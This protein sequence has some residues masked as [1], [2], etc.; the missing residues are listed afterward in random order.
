MDEQW[1][2][3]AAQLGVWFAGSLGP[4]GSVYNVGEQVEIHGPIVP[5]ILERAHRIVLD[6]AETLRFTIADGPGPTGDP[7]ASDGPF[8]VRRDAQVPVRRLDFSADANP[9]EAAEAWLR[10][11]MD[12]AFDLVQGPLYAPALLTVGP[13]SHILY[14]RYHHVVMDAWSSALI[15]RRTAQVYS[16]MVTDQP[17]HGTPFPPFRTLLEREG[18]YRGSEEQETDRRYWLKRLRNAPA[19]VSLSDRPYSRP[20]EILRQ[21]TTLD[22]HLADT[23]RSAAAQ[24]GV[25]W[26]VLAVVATAAY[27]GA[28][29]GESTVSVGLPVSGRLDED[30]RN[31]PGMAVNV[32]PLHIAV[33]PELPLSKVAKQVWAQTTRAA[34]HSRYRMEDLR[35][36]LAWTTGA[37]LPYGPV[38]NVMAFDYDIDFG[39]HRARASSISRRYT[40]D[41]SIAFHEGER[42][43]SIEA[44]FDANNQMYSQE[45]LDAHVERFLLFLGRMANAGPDQRVGSL[46]LL[47]AAERA[48]VLGAW[49]GSAEAEAG[50]GA[51]AGAPVGTV[52]ALF[53]ERV[54][55]APDAAAVLSAGDEVAFTYVELNARANRLARL[56]VERGVGPEQVVALALPRSPELVVAVLAVLKA[57]AAYLPID[58]AY[59]VE[60]IG[61]MLRDAGPSVVLADSASVGLLPQEGV[62]ALVLNG[63]GVEER[64]AGLSAA[65]LSDADRVA[66]LVP[67]HPAYVIY[68]SGST[69]VPKGVV[70]HHAGLVNLA[71]AQ[72]EQWQ[73]DTHSR[74]LQF[75]S[76]SF[77]A[78]AS[79]IFTALLSGGA[80]VTADAEQLAPGAALA[81]VLRDASVSHCTLPPSALPLLEVADVPQSMTLVVAGE[82][83]GPDAVERWSA[84]RQMINAY[85]P[86][87]TTVC[88]TMSEPLSG[89]VVPPIGHPI[90][91]V[92]VYVLNAGLAPVPPG[93]PG[94]LYVAGAGVARGYLGRPGL[95]GQRFVADPYG[96]PGTRMYR[97]GDLARWNP[98]GTLQF[99]GRADDQVKLRG[100][101]IELGEIEAALTAA[102]GVVGAVAVI[103]EDRPGDHRLVGY[104]VPE[105]NSH[106]VDT[107][108]IRT[109][110][111]DRLPD[112]MVPAAVVT[113]TELPLTPNGKLD[114]KALPAPDYSSGN[115]P[116]R[117]PRDAR[118][119]ILAGL[120]AEVLGLESSQVSVEDD[121]FTLGGHSLLAMRLIGR[122][123]AVL[124]TD[125]AIRDLFT[126]PTIA[127][128][129]RTLDTGTDATSRPALLP[130]TTRPQPIPLSFAQRRLWF[131][132]RLEGPSP[133]YNVP[134]VLRLTGPL[135]ADALQAALG[136]VVERHEALRT[137]FPDVD[138]QPHQHICPAAEARPDLTVETIDEADLT[139]AIDQAVRHSFDLATELPLR[140]RLF[141][142]GED[143]HVLVLTIHH[144]AGDGW[145]MGP[146]ARDLST[147]YAARR[148]GHT[149]AWTPLPVQYADY[150]LWQRELLGDEGDPDSLLASQA[151]YWREALA[152]LPERLELPTDHPYPEQ[153][154][155]EGASL[156][157]H[158][159]A[160]LHQAL[161][162]LARSTQT[163]VFMVLQAAI[164]VLLHRLG[165]GTD[166]PIG[167]PVAGR[168]E[169]ELDDLVGF[170]VNTLVLRTD[171]TGDPTFTELLDRV[172]ERNLN[173]YAHQD[174][175]FESLVEA[176]NPTRSLAHHPLFQVTL[177]FNNTPPTSVNFPAVEAVREFADVQAARMDLTVNL[178]ERHGDD[179]APDGIAGVLTYRTDLFEPGTATALVE[180]LLRVLRAVADNPGG[181]VAAVG[182]LSDGERHQLI[183]RWNDTAAPVPSG[184]VTEL[185]Q[186]QAHATPDATALITDGAAHT[187]YAELNT[188][189]NQLARILI[190][191]DVGPEHVVAL[192][193]PRSPRLI[194]AVLAVLK[195]GAAYLP[196]DT[197]YPVDRIRFMVRD[198]RPTLVLTDTDTDTDTDTTTDGLWA[199]GTPV[200]RLDDPAVQAQLA[201]LDASDA[202]DPA[203]A[204]HPES[205]AYVIYTSGSTGV[206]KG[207]V[208]HHAGL[209]NLA[210]A[211]S[212]QWQIG[213]RSRVLQ[214]A[215]PS[216]DAAASE[217]FTALLSGGALVLAG[218]ERLMPG[219][220]LGRVARDAG[221]THCTLPPSALNVLDVADVPQSMTLVVAGE[222]CG[223]DAVERWSAGRQMI[224]AYGP[225]ETTVCATMSEPL[226][227]AVVPPIGRPIANVRTYVL[228]AG[229][230]PVPPGVPG[231]LYVAGAGVA[232]GYLGRPGLTGQRFVA[233]PYGPPGTRMY[234][235]GDL[236][237]WNPDGTLQFLGRADDQV[238]LRGF[239]IELGEIEAALKG[240]PGVAGAAAVIREDRPGDRRLVGYVVPENNSHGVDTVAI[241]NLL[242]DRLPDYMVPAAVVPLPQLPLT[243]NGKLDRKALPAPDYTLGATSTT[244]AP[245]TPEEKALTALYAEVLG[246]DPARIGLDDSFFALGGDSISSIVLVSRAR[247]HG[248]D[249]SPRDIFKDQTPKQL[250]RTARPLDVGRAQPVAD[251]GVGRV[252]LTPIMRWLIEPGHSFDTF[253][254][255]RLVQVPAGIGR[256]PLLEV[257]QA[258]LDRHD[259]LRAR[260]T[261]AGDEGEAALEVPRAG[262]KQ[263]DEVLT[264]VDCAGVSAA[265]RE[266]LMA[267]HARQAQDRL[268][269]YDGVM[270]QAVWFDNGPQESGRLLLT[271]HHLVVD[272]VSWRILLPDLA[273]AGAAVLAGR[274]PE[275]APVPTSFK[276][277][278]ERLGA[279]AIDPDREA[280]LTHWT[281]TL[282]GVEPALGERELSSSVDTA[283]QLLSLR[284]T[285]PVELSEALVGRVPAALHAGVD[286]VLLTAFVLAIA[287]WRNARGG[288][289]SSGG[290]AGNSLL[291][292]VEGHGR[293]DGLFDGVD[294]SRT[295][296]WFTAVTP[297]RLDPGRVSW[298]ELRRGGPAAGRALQRV[299]EQL[300]AASELRIDHGLLRHL[301][302][303][304]A[305]VLAALPEPQVAFNYFGRLPAGGARGAGDWQQVD[306][307]PATGG[308]DRRMRL[309]H[310]L[311]V[312]AVTAEGPS[313][314]QLTATWSWPRDVLAREDV[315]RLGAGWVAQLKALAAHA[316][317][318]DTA[319][320]TPSDLS[321]VS[322]SQNQISRLEKKWRAKR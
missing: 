259:M 221:V 37:G 102:P 11:D 100:F 78:A 133:T 316:D 79:E 232:R 220:A 303:R 298:G 321:L 84:G 35:R 189:A 34:R 141:S 205:P 284:V 77:D 307:V 158:V 172:R 61:F 194:V 6:E 88:A 260:L 143:E 255:A 9:R 269:P 151:A 128:L 214:F 230:S 146:L 176:V 91:N 10:S 36:E 115:G 292:D 19:P 191:R 15:T 69:G 294:T 195:A 315:E 113:V 135:D 4:G 63:V 17:D 18:S 244:R 127:T 89:A 145:S 166:I 7:E 271:V 83:C 50:A 276:G 81:A 233:D 245:S 2:L 225:S 107:V 76:P 169:D 204:A 147:A 33:G 208:A 22:A 40:D 241:R 171:L 160:E 282:A 188:R 90:A 16:A 291:V 74:V 268:A 218:A 215:S 117:A 305:P 162:A 56:L 270:V 123:R 277:W 8:Q 70:A 311:M 101:R 179:G 297:V 57:G 289:G 198:A 120:F 67:D 121:F 156:P 177:A 53:E 129:A 285:V 253:F 161:T 322:L 206:P 239:R 212:E 68:T 159:D 293:E 12:T 196:I 71:L 110:L 39:G 296:G 250:A 192:A 183:D 216:F 64:L 106:G 302:P 217:I 240:C 43:G 185:F 252:P 186:A 234:R 246:L 258:L 265:E 119:E 242:A 300:R 98:D 256:G 1:P 51:G 48:S 122:I 154:G 299:K 228:D 82:A 287:Q 254:Q 274:T 173:A 227:G 20:T 193:L 23:L 44:H 42:E 134:V 262:G 99:L 319:G 65:D 5:D 235:T 126:A 109:L 94:E 236:A 148:D 47:T 182:V 175:P 264:R 165:A 209:V 87:E 202:T 28:V 152:G 95:T 108:A 280:S 92:R 32:V 80:L 130:A 137:V 238:K 144:I 278:A 201:R 139:T 21:R 290:P 60:R 124:G 251:D 112:Y 272:G 211:Q 75:A 181:R 96:P 131:L 200:L 41:F 224:N 54:A 103:R 318:P 30:E 157:V 178:A 125:L 105:N 52:P 203:T 237:R 27:V 104:V 168:S 163:T 313:G 281:E 59:P 164:G 279:L 58:T 273:A 136:D 283:E 85:G 219:E 31:T 229:L 73:I 150:T 93:V 231:E 14:S 197:G 317:G 199:D 153:A 261:H 184:T 170:F 174:I 288:P 247:E 263:A 308:L 45:E 286:D 309:T 142:L 249:I 167:T 29:T 243:P 320:R 86:S 138:G 226:T 312:N 116:S 266:R 267:D 25:N 24:L 13:N 210:L 213:P 114:R 55:G 132:Y 275:L 66:P 223:P 314:P 3:T 111:A 180:R 62:T 304:T 26:S 46:S 149:P 72:S 295:V 49:S 257:V 140:A 155:Y 97:T 118:E 310:A 190:E 187:S 38:V 306:G 301:N 248:L 222:A 207:V